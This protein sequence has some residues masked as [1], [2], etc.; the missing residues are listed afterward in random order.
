MLSTG[1]KK[2]KVFSPTVTLKVTATMGSFMV[3]SG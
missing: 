3:R 2:V 1:E